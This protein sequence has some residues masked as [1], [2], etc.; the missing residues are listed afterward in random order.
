[1]ERKIVC[2]LADDNKI[3]LFYPKENASFAD[4]KE[5]DAARW[6]FSHNLSAGRSTNIMEDARGFYVPLSSRSYSF[7]VIGMFCG[8]DKEDLDANQ[9]SLLEAVAAQLSVALDRERLYKEQE[10]IRM[11]M[12]KEKMHSNLLRS[13]SHDLRTPLAA[14]AGASSTLLLSGTAIDKSDY[15]RLLTDIM[16][17]ATWL[18]RLVE[19]LLSLTKAEEGGLSLTKEWE[20][21]EEV[22]LSALERTM[23]RRKSHVV[24][25]VL[26]DEPFTAPMDA[27][28]IPQVLTNLL[29]NAIQYTPPGS[30]ITIRIRDNGREAVFEVEDDGPG[31]P[32]QYH[33]VIFNRFVTVRENSESDRRGLGLGLAI[34]KSIVE[35]HSG[36]ITVERA[37]PRGSLFKFFLPIPQKSAPDHT[38]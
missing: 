33:S 28:L 17:D 29:D 20:V 32:D 37:N 26:P 14:I 5:L 38:T 8:G 36:R 21:V 3:E 19:N 24:R 13:I 7:G 31:I 27:A 6:V 10:K 23:G 1:M 11:E 30:T 35:A 18:T 9:R 25:T 4:A 12:E 2:F 15:E 34:C 22:V 16:N